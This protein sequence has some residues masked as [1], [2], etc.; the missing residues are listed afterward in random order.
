MSKVS[1][2]SYLSQRPL[3][4]CHPVI[5]K[6]QHKIDMCLIF[7]VSIVLIGLVS[8]VLG[9]INVSSVCFLAVL[10]DWIIFE[11]YYSVKEQL[12]RASDFS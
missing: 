11:Y 6:L 4:S 12:S 1:Y 9:V 2:E 3:A 10:I 8:L 7:G 5:V